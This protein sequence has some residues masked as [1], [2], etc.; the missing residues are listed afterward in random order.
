MK[1]YEDLQNI[2]QSSFDAQAKVVGEWGKGW[3]AIS[4][5]LTDYTK[6]TFE[7]TTGTFEKLLQAKTVDQALEIQSS[8]AKRAYEDYVRQ[9]TR[10]GSMYA[11]LA[12]DAVRPLQRSFEQMR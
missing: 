7:D 9:M 1:T 6:R 5:E 2:G 4:V 3:Q 8:Y 10:L 11:A 12:Q